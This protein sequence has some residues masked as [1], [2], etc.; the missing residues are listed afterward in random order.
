MNVNV[1]DVVEDI[2]AL[3]RSGASIAPEVL[4]D[5][6]TPLAELVDPGGSAA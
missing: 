6:G 5:E 1:R 3:I 4:A 2:R